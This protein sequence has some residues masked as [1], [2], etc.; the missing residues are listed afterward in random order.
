MVVLRVILFRLAS[1][2]AYGALVP[3]YERVAWLYSDGEWHTWR[4]QALVPVA[5]MVHGA[6][7][8]GRRAQVLEVGCGT[9]A[10]LAELVHLPCAVVGL[11]RSS[12]ML[13]AT[14]RRA[15]GKVAL[16]QA[17]SE[18]LP[19]AA[20]HLDAIV[21]TFPTNYAYA[22][23]TW[24]EFARV[25]A[26]GGQVVWVDAGELRAPSP[27]ARV[28]QG[29]LLPSAALAGVTDRIARRLSDLGFG[30]ELQIVELAHSR[31][32]VLRARPAKG[33]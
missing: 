4:R 28:L 20:S 13:A 11:D 32:R 22:A 24:Q 21:L 29:L 9:G 19:L 30:I 6:A 7:A 2:L 27:G 25:L 23:A 16:V 3:L 12:A 15:G 5:E 31:V 1:W 18:A 14:R 10:L 33:A 17:R 26:P 8:V